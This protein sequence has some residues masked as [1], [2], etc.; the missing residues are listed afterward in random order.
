MSGLV[1]AALLLHA[2][3]LARHD[4]VMFNQ[5]FRVADAQAASIEG[6]SPGAICHHKGDGSGKPESP[7]SDRGKVPSPCP[8]C[9]GLVAACAVSPSAP[10]PP[11]PPLF[12]AYTVYPSVQPHIFEFR[13]FRSPP[14]RGPPAFA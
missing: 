2:V 12:Y 9:L 8:V 7:P 4:V 3:L 14:S 13:K 1:M 11:A 5:A 6:L 10:P